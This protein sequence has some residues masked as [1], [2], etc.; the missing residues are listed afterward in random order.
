MELIIH[1]MNRVHPLLP[2]LSQFARN[3]IKYCNEPSSNIPY[4]EC[5][6]HSFSVEQ[7][8]DPPFLFIFDI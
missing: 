2:L 6:F 7:L 4:I 3:H 1:P 5:F 8:L